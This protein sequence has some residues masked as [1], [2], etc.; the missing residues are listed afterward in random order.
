MSKI[1]KVEDHVYRELGQLRD[2]GET[3]SQV[4]EKFL[5]AR[6]YLLNMLNSLE[7]HLKIERWREERQREIAA[8]AAPPAPPAPAPDR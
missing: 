2:R 7:S 4:I 8:A 1:I 6:G 3:F 5:F